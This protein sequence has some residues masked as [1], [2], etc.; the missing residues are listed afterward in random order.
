MTGERMNINIES[1]QLGGR[2]I[3]LKKT[4]FDKDGLQGIYVPGNFKTELAREITSEALDEARVPY[5]TNILER[6]LNAI[7]TAGAQ[8]ARKSNRIVRV[9]VKSNYKLYLKNDD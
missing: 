1:V 6:G 2:I 7:T 5:S 4:V 3:L 8:I 9:T